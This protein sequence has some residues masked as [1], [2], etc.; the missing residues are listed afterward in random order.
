[1]PYP[2][3]DP[4]QKFTAQWAAQGSGFRLRPGY[5]IG[6]ETI[7]ADPRRGHTRRRSSPQYTLRPF[8]ELLSA[9]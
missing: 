5:E 2:T 8:V 3:H 9:G 6:R 7:A 4:S 1:M